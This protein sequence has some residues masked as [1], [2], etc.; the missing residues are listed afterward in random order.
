MSTATLFDTMSLQV[1][2]RCES[3]L[4]EANRE[5]EAISAEARAQSASLREATLNATRDEMA[6]LD[7]RWRQKAEAEVVKAA[8]VVKNEGVQEVLRVVEA[9]ARAIVE[10]PEFPRILDALL[11]E[12]MAVAEGDIVALAP[13]AR[14]EHVRQWMAQNGHAQVPVEASPEFWDGVAIQDP[15]R[16]FRI[17]NTLTGRFARV[18]EEARKICMTSLFDDVGGSTG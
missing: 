15:R 4:S 5:A 9:E 13:E 3:N 17:S 18:A 7:E 10:G 11:A 14:V 6:V 2:E 8:L 12:L 16:T 1:A